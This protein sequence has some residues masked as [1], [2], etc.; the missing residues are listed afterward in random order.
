MGF[1]DAGL[2]GRS[3]RSL[4]KTALLQFFDLGGELFLDEILAEGWEACEHMC[5][6]IC[7]YRYLYIY[8]LK[9]LVKFPCI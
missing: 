3:H 8:I 2:C 7:I 6:D 5:D 1:C 9:I 4:K